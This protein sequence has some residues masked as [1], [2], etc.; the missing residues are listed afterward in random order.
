LRTV[1]A[2]LLRAAGDVEAHDFPHRLREI[3]ADFAKVEIG[4]PPEGWRIAHGAAGS[5][6][7]ALDG[8]AKIVRARAAQ[9]PL[10]ALYSTPLAALL[11][12]NRQ[13]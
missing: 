8:Q 7:V 1:F 9:E 4:A 10:T 5:M 11:G 2:R 12:G 3:D 6:T 13:P